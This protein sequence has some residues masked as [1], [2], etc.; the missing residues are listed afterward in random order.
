MLANIYLTVLIHSCYKT[1]IKMIYLSNEKIKHKCYNQPIL[2]LIITS[3][4]EHISVKETTGLRT[5]V[6]N[7]DTEL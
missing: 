3:K 7:T 4:L 1:T 2:I 6:S 5:E